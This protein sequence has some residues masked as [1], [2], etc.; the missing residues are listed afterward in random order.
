M[1]CGDDRQDFRTVRWRAWL[2][3]FLCCLAVAMCPRASQSGELRPIVKREG[4]TIVVPPYASGDTLVVEGDRLEHDDWAAIGD[5]QNQEPFHLSLM[6]GQDRM[7]EG[8]FASNNDRM[9]SIS[10]PTMKYLEE[11]A[12]SSCT[13]LRSFDFPNLV[14]MGYHAFSG[15]EG[16]V[17]VEL[18]ASLQ[19]IGSPFTDC[20]NLQ[21]IHIS[22]EST[23]FKTVDGI[24]Y[25]KDEKRLISYP[26]GKA[27]TRFVSPVEE[28]DGYVFWGS[29]GKLRHVSF[30]AI[31][32]L[33]NDTFWR[34]VS[35][36][37]VELPNVEVMHDGAFFHCT[38]LREVAAPR[39]AEAGVAS[40]KECT[41]LETFTA[42]RLELIDHEMFSHCTSLQSASFPK[43][44]SVGAE[45]FCR[46]E[47]LVSLDLRSV[48]D[49]WISA[50]ADCVSLRELQLG[51]PPKVYESTFSGVP[52]PI[53]LYVPKDA[54]AEYTEEYLSD[55]PAGTRVVAAEAPDTP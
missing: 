15:S 26:L 4:R 53:T 46:C 16:L 34:A 47:K 40:F 21:E 17:S 31:K 9:L 33:Y 2:V 43:V 49:I 45:A 5:E 27:D 52:G 22:P 30:P 6:N 51:R 44:V 10:S 8:E 50:F 1:G 24:L 7:Y 14:L 19:D 23:L 55:Y 20:N 25:D 37:T 35:I 18:P 11:G 42:P 36:E 3:L 54:L 12:F 38:A 29:S 32:V 48:E 13:S 28:V 41:S 39:L